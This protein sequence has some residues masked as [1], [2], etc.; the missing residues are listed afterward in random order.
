MSPG[1]TGRGGRGVE[2]PSVTLSRK[3]THNQMEE[4]VV[5]LE[6]VRSIARW[7][8]WGPSTVS[9]LDRVWSEAFRYWAVIL[10]GSAETGV[11][12]LFGNTSG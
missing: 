2:D 8:R 7:E 10:A 5:I 6:S 9:L 4:V 12:H 3:P 1:G 11:R